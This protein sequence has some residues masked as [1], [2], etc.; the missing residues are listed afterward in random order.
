MSAGKRAKE[1]LLVPSQPSPLRK[2]VSDPVDVRRPQRR[3]RFQFGPRNRSLSLT[4]SDEENDSD[5]E[6]QGDTKKEEEADATQLSPPPPRV[7]PLSLTAKA[8]KP[9]VPTAEVA[10]EAERRAR[11][12]QERA[13]AMQRKWEAYQQ[14]L[15]RSSNSLLDSI[16]NPTGLS[17]SSSMPLISLP[18][19]LASTSPNRHRGRSMKIM[20]MTTEEE[21]ED[22]SEEPPTADDTERR[23]EREQLRAQR[24]L[25]R[26]SLDLLHHKELLSHEHEIEKLELLDQMAAR[27]REIEQLKRRLTHL[28]EKLHRADRDRQSALADVKRFKDALLKQHD[29]DSEHMALVDTLRHK[30][31]MFTHRAEEAERKFAAATLQARDTAALRR[32]LDEAQ[33]EL[34]KRQLA[35]ETANNRL[36]VLQGVREENER[37]HK[38]LR[39]L[40]DQLSHTASASPPASLASLRSR[41]KNGKRRGDASAAFARVLAKRQNRRKPDAY[42]DDD[43]ESDESSDDNAANDIQ[44]SKKKKKKKDNNNHNPNNGTLT[45]SGRSVPNLARFSLPT[46]AGASKVGGGTGSLLSSKKPK[47]K[48]T[49]NFLLRRRRG[50]AAA[51]KRSRSRRSLF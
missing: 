45:R 5:G 25:E 13:K 22:E 9:H 44:D 10:A 6:E 15:K 8:T 40:Q 51:V 16:L 39:Q 11:L 36:K 23:M 21:D 38:Q 17:P 18:A 47:Y 1:E 19:P 27:D 50:G 4:S 37:L 3:R 30:L 34:G 7:A 43:F 33:S 35:L 32:E 14:S 20:E 12:G 26:A 41:S 31:T 49:T 28:K 46:V 48:S 24:R 29:S 2:S 42:D